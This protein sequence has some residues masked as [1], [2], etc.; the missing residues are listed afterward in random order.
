MN[1]EKADMVFTD[2]PY[3]IEE[4]GDRSQRGGISKGGK[5]KDF[6]DDSVEYAV[7]AFNIIQKLDIKKQVW[8]CAY[9]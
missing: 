3:G 2:P 6:K 7:K 4:K 8:F 9:K 5:C 1:S